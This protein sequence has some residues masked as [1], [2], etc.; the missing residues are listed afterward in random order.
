MK[1]RYVPSI[2]CIEDNKRKSEKRADLRKST[3][4]KIH[5]EKND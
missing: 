5:E 1:I 4:L 2:C 3:S